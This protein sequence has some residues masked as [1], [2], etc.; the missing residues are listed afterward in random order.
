MVVVVVVTAG[1]WVEEDVFKDDFLVR[2]ETLLP[3]REDTLLPR[4]DTLLPRKDTLLPRK[5]TLPRDEALLRD[6]DEEVLRGGR[7][8]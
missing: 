3:A 4:E 1:E 8:L 7:G 5:E 6:D 2:G